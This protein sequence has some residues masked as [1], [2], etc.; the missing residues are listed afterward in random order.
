MTSWV[1][2]LHPPRED[3]AATTT[4]AEVF[5]AGDPAIGSWVAAGALREMRV[6]LLRGRDSA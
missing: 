5:M 6:S 1:C 3:F 4:D 2:F